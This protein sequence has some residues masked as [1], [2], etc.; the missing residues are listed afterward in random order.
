MESRKSGLCAPENN[1]GRRGIGT[2]KKMVKVWNSQ[3]RTGKEYQL[4]EQRDGYHDGLLLGSSGTQRMWTGVSVLCD[5]FFFFN[6]TCLPLLPLHAE[7]FVTK[8]GALY[9]QT[10]LISEEVLRNQIL[11][12]Y[13]LKVWLLK[14]SRSFSVSRTST[15][16]NDTY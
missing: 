5:F 16:L 2:R 4:G 11:K 7:K 14:V 3:L 10:Q 9:W 12:K 1:R 13:Y 8:L 6:A 15:R